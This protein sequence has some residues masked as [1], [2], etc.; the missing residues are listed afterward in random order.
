[1]SVD[2]T[3]NIVVDSPMGKR[4]STFELTADGDNLNGHGKG[5]DGPNPIKEGTVKGDDVSWKIDV[6]QPMPMTLEFNGK[7]DGDTIA[8]TTKAGAFGSMPFEGKRA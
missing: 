2:G 4:E 1:M 8:G 7:V 6:K 5:P 3:W